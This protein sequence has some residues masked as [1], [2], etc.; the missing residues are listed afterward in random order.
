M[1]N[2]LEAEIEARARGRH[3]VHSAPV[4][5]G[6][7]DAA[8]A[9]QRLNAL[10]HE[11]AAS[12]MRMPLADL[13]PAENLANYGIDSI[14]ITE[15][16]VQISRRLG[17]AVAPTTFF[18]ARNLI[19]L[20]GLLEQR[21]GG[22]V[23]AALAAEAPGAP[24][25][26]A[27]A[28]AAPDVDSW[29]RRHGAVRRKA[30]AKHAPATVTPE[31]GR[32]AMPIAII[33][34]QGTFPK[35]PDIE[36]LRQHLLK[37]E[38]CIEVV[39]EERW[40]WRDVHG[41]PRKGPFTDVKYGGF[42]PDAD[43]FDA[44]FFGI[45][46]REAELIDPQHRLFME[47]VWGLLETAGHAPSRLAGRKIGLFL[48]INL[49]DY[50]EMANRAGLREAQQLT[51]L[52]HA[53]CPNRLSFLLDIH[54]PSEVID[55]ACSSSLVAIHRAV[56]SIRHEGCEMAIAGGSNLMLSPMQHIMFSR[57]GMICADGRCKTFSAAA[58]GYARADGVG[59]VLLKPLADA[60]RDNDR[61]LGVILAS[62][63]H[64][65]GGA[66]SLTAPNPQAQ[67][68]L[69]AEAHREARV[70]PRSIG[71]IECHGTG[72][73]L[74]DPIEIEGL[75][76]AFDLL[77]R[78][79]GLAPPAVPHIGLGSIK[80][81]IGH[82]ET[83]AGVAG[84][85][86]TLLA[87]EEGTR[88]R[89]LHCEE[90]NPLID[91]GGSPFMLLDR[92]AAWPR[93][94]IDGREEPRRAG[95]SSFG[96]GGTNVHIVVEEYRG[97][98]SLPAPSAALHVVP[99]SAR[100]AEALDGLLR[101]MLPHVPRHAVRDLAGTLQFGRDAFAHR[102]AFVAEDSRDLATQIERFLSGERSGTAHGV[103][104]RGAA[105]RRIEEPGALTPRALADLWA[106]GADV[107][108][109]ALAGA[110][111]FQR[112]PL[113]SY[114]FE[115]RRYWLPLPA[116]KAPASAQ[117]L[118]QAGEGLFHATL[119]ATDSF[120]RDHMVN[121]VP[122][123]PGVMYLE[124]ARDAATRAGL[125]PVALRNVTWLQ[126]LQVREE[127]EVSIRL[128]PTA[129]Q[130]FRI[131]ITSGGGVLHAQMTASR[132]DGG[133]ASH[134][135]K[136]LEA[137]HRE[138]LD[139]E[140]IYR[141]HAERGIAFG[142]AHRSLSSLSRAREG[143]ATV[144][145]LARISLPPSVAGTLTG[146][147]LHPSI[148]DGALQAA[149]GM[150]PDGETGT[151][152][153]FGLTGLAG[154]G[155]LGESMHVFIRPSAESGK[156]DLDLIDDEGNVVY[157]LTGFATRALQAP[158]DG[159]ALLAFTPAWKQLGPA[160]AQVSSEARM[161][162]A[163]RRI[164]VT[165]PAREADCTV[166]HVP[167]TGL[168]ARAAAL[169]KILGQ[170]PAGRP[171]LVQLLLPDDGAGPALHATLQT[172]ALEIPGLRTQTIILE[173]GA[174]AGTAAA[175]LAEQPAGLYRR[176]HGRFERLGHE[177]AALPPGDFP[178]RNTGVYLVTGGGGALGQAV[179]RWVK[180]K[181]P[182]AI[183][184]RM[185]R[186]RPADADETFIAADAA[187]RDEVTGM[188]AMIRAR[189]GA[190][191]GVFHCAGLLRDAPL[192]EKTTEDFAAVLAPKLTAARILDE[193]IGAE[194][195]DA[196]VLF[197]S[198]SGVFGNPGQADYA[199]ANAA[200]DLFAEDRAR[201]VAAGTR[202]GATISIAWPLWQ[203]G[204][205]RMSPETIRLM[206]QTTGLAPLPLAHG[207]DALQRAMAARFPRLAIGFGEG[208]K[209][210][211]RFTMD[212]PP[213]PAVSPSR[214]PSAGLRNRLAEEL[215]ACAAGQLKVSVEDLATN[216]ELT[217]YGFD[218]I[219]F[220]QFANAL[221]DRFGLEIGPTLFFECQTI[222]LLAEK[223]A[224]THG[225]M[226]GER[227]GLV[228][229]APASPPAAPV[230]PPQPAVTREAVEARPAD[231]PVAIISM[232]GIFPGAPDI[233]TFWRNLSE[234][235]DSIS[236]IPPERW[237]WRAIWGNPQKED[238][239]TNVKWGGF[240]DG[241][242]EFDAAFFGLSAPEARGTDPQQRLLLTESWKLFERAGIAPQS[243]SGRRIGVFIGI[244][245]TGYGRLLAGGEA[246]QAYMM[247]G[248]APS[249]G[250]NRI[251]HFYNL[252]GPSVAVETACSSAL[253][254]VH[255]AAESIRAGECE[256]A[257]AGGVNTLLLPD[258]YI[259]FSR[260]GMLSA[261]G[262]SKPFS[263]D[264]NGYARGE[265]IGLFL[266]KPLSA[267][268]RDGDEI[269][270]VIR[271][272]AENHGGRASSLTAPNPRAQAD[273]LRGVYRKANIDPRSVS[274]I[275]AHGTGT[276]LGDPI[277][278][279]A[280]SAAFTTLVGEAEARHGAGPALRCA[281][282]SVKSNIGHLEIAAGAA[283]L[284]KVLLQIRHRTI[285]GT[286]HAARIN[287]LL[288]LEGSG[289][290]VATATQ[291]WTP[292]RGAGG[293]PLPLRA[294]VSSFGFGGANAHLVV[295]AYDG[296]PRA[297]P[298]A[299][300]N[301]PRMIVVSARNEDQL[302][303]T[304]RNLAGA[305]AAGACSLGDAAFTLATGRDAMEHRLAF[306]ATSTA[307]AASHLA[308]FAR[309]ETFPGLHRGETR[310]SRALVGALESDEAITAAIEGLA[311]RGGQD[312]LLRLWVMGV[313]VDWARVMPGGRRAAL[314]TY[315]FRREHFWPRK[316]ASPAAIPPAPASSPPPAAE[317]ADQLPPPPREDREA[318]LRGRLTELAAA[319]LEVQPSMIDAEAELGDYGFDSVSMT[320]FAARV[321]ADLDL[322]LTPPDFFTFPTIAKLAGH[323]L[324]LKPGVSAARPQPVAGT[325]A[326]ALPAAMDHDGDPIVI[327]GMSCEF[328]GARG[329]EE[330]WTAL[331]EG[332]D[333]ITRIPAGRWDWRALDGDPRKDPGKTD[334]H[335]GGFIEGL[336]E[337]D[338]L[339]FNIAPR[340]ARY[341]DPQHRLMMLH[342]WKAIE[343][344]GESPRALAG[345]RGGVFVGTAASGYRDI[346]GADTGTE[347][348]V[349]TGSVA[350]IG[351]NRISYFLDW[352]G[353]SEP[354]ETACSSS[355]VA[356]HRACQAIENG[357]CDFALAGGV[358]SIVTPEAHINF[359]KA[360]MLAPDGRC[361][362]FSADA[363]GYVRGEGVGMI[364][365]KRLSAALRD[366]NPVLAI[367]KGTAVN[368]GGKAN[369]L[370]AP[371]GAAQAELLTAAWRKAGIDP[372]TI[373]YI[374][375]HGTGTALGDPV[376]I[377]AIKSAWASSADQEAD[378]APRCAIGA[379]KTNIGHLELAAGIAGVIKTVLQMQAGTLAP[380]L[381]AGAIN[382]YIS[383]AGT[384][385]RLLSRAE[386][387]ERLVTRQGH[388]VPRRAG[389]S[390]FGYGG[391]NS[392]VVLEE[393]IP[394]QRPGALPGGPLPIVLSAHDGE[395][396]RELA[397][398]L[399]TW[400][401]DHPLSDEGLADFAYTLQAGRTAMRHRLAFAARSASE[402]REHLS[403]Y[404]RGQSGDIATGIAPPDRDH[405]PPLRLAAE[406]AARGWVKGAAI[407]WSAFYHGTP[408]R[409]RLPSY[410]F[411][412]EI[413]RFDAAP[414][415]KPEITPRAITLRLTPDTDGLSDHRFQGACVVP[416]AYT[417][418]LA[419]SH[420]NLALPL[421][422]QGTLWSRPLAVPESGLELTLE[423]T[424]V[425]GSAGIRIIA[426]G[427]EAMR[428]SA[429][430]AGQPPRDVDPGQLRQDCADAVSPQ[431][432]YGAFERLGLS[433]GP[434]YRA[435][436]GLWRGPGQ[437]LAELGLP[438]AARREMP[439][440]PELLDAAFQSALALFLSNSGE[441]AL[442]FALTSFA[443][444]Q[445]MPDRL[446]AH[447]RLR[448]ASPTQVEID[449]TLFDGQGRVIA[450]AEGFTARRTPAPSGAGPSG[451]GGARQRITRML[452]EMVARETGV[453]AGNIE[454]ALPL[455]HYGIDSLLIT[456]LTEALERHTGP[457]PATLFFEHRSIDE[458][459]AWLT[460]RHASSLQ[461]TAQNPPAQQ[462]P[463][464]AA[465]AAHVTAQEAIAIVG[466]AGRYPGA[467]NIEQFWNALAAGRD[468]VTTIPPGRWDHD[469]FYDPQPGT[470]GRTNSRWGGFIDGHDRF[471]PLFF[472]IAPGEAEY[473]D[474][475]ERLFL[476]CAWE[477]LEDS[478]HTRANLAPL[479][480]ALK[481]GNVGVFV[482]VMYE[483]YQLYGAERSM[484]GQPVA[485]GGSAA[486]IANR[487]S[488]FCDFHGPSMTV[489]T[490]CSS[491]LTAIHLAC[492]SIRSGSCAAA[493]AG[494]VN[495]TL[496]PNKYIALS[497][498]RFL[499]S[500][501]RCAAFGQ[502]G[503]GY[504][505]GE[506]VGAVVLKPLSLAL[507]DGN[508]IHAVIRGSAL[509]HGGKTNGYTVP[510]PAAQSA[511][512]SNAFR[513]AGVNPADVS[514]VEAHG[515]GTSL[516][517]PIEI[518][519]LARAFGEGAQRAA[520][521]AIGSVKSNI[522][523]CESAAGIAGLT[524]IL[525]QMRH[526]ALAPSLHA[527]S[528]NPALRLAETPFVVQTQL[529]PWEPAGG[530]RLASLSSFGA[531]GSN[532]HVL[533][534]DVNNE[535]PALPSARMAFPLSARTQ[536]RLDALLRNMAGKLAAL[537]EALIPHAA[538][539]LQ[540]GRESFE[541]RVVLLARSKEDLLAALDIAIKGGSGANVMRGHVRAP[542]ARAVQSF[543]G[544]DTAARAWCAG[545][546]VD[547]SA[548]RTGTGYRR[549]SL[550]TYAF[551]QDRFWIPGTGTPAPAA[552]EA[553]V[554]M[555][556]LF[557]PEWREA[558]LVKASAPARCLT[559]LCDWPG[560]PGEIMAALGGTAQCL[561]HAGPVAGRYAS[562]AKRLV[563]IIQQ[564]VRTGAEKTCLQLVLPLDGEGDLM[565]GLSGL[566]RTAR[567]EHPTLQAQTIGI[568]P[569]TPG[570]PA[571]ILEERES[572]EPDIRYTGGKRL[573]RAWREIAAPDRPASPWREGGAY[574][575]TG[576]AGA[577][578]L[579]LCEDIAANAPGATI[580]LAH[581]SPL[582]AG[583]SERFSRLRATVHA[584]QT[585][586]TDAR[587]VRALADEITAAHGR[588]D[589]LIHAAGTT[590]DRMLVQKPAQEVDDVLRPKV[591]GWES[592][593]DA[594]AGREPALVLLFAS[595]AGALGN[596]GQADYAAANAWLDAVAA[597]HTAAR[598]I[599]IDWPYWRDG[600]MRMPQAAVE[601]M[602]RVTG[603][604]PLETPAALKALHAIIQSSETQ[605]LVLDGDHQRLRNMMRPA[606][607]TPGAGSKSPAPAPDLAWLTGQ[608]AD[609][610]KIPADQIDPEAPLDRYGVDSIQ[611]L[612]IVE[613]LQQRLGPLPPTLLLENPSIA[614]LARALNAEK[615]PEVTPAPAVRPEAV[616][617]GAA[618]EDGAIAIIGVA[619]RYPG[620]ETLDAFW[621]ALRDGADCITEI[622]AGRWPADSLGFG[623]R[624]EAGKS[625]C[626]LGGFISRVDGFD[627]P[628]FGYTPRQAE[629]ADPQE[630]LFLETA[631]HALENASHTRRMLRDRYESSVGVFVGAM[632][633]QYRA[634]EADGEARPQLTLAS[635]A[636]IANRLSFF[637][638]AQG[639]SVAVDSM[640]SAG[641]QAVHQACQ[642][643]R[644]G[645]CRLA[646]AGGVNLTI[647]PDKYI[648]LSRA[649]L[650][651]SHRGSRS[652][653]DGDGYLP[654]EGVGAVVLKPL[655]AAR[656][657]G[658]R[659]LGIIRASAAN[660]AGHSA[661]YASPSA[662][663]QARLVSGNFAASGI[664]PRTI[665]Y[666]EA[667]ANGS[668]LGDAIEMRALARAFAALP[669]G[670]CAIGS[671]KANIGHAE[672]ASGLAQLTK[673]LLQFEHRMLAPMPRIETG[674]PHIDFDALPFHLPAR[675]GPWERPLVDG[676]LQ[677]RRASISAFGAGG[678]N[679]HLI[680]EEPPATEA[681]RL[682]RSGGQS[683]HLFV[684]SAPTRERLHAVLR[685]M[686]DWLEGHHDVSLAALASAL[687]HRRERWR[688]QMSISAATRAELL[689][690]LTQALA[691]ASFA[692]T[693]EDPPGL[694][695]DALPTLPAYPFAAERHWLQPLRQP[696][697][698]AG[699]HPVLRHIAAET[700][701]DPAQIDINT[702]LTGLGLD[703]MAQL[704]LLT[705]LQR[706][707]GLTLSTRDLARLPT[708]ADIIGATAAESRPLEQPVT[709]QARDDAP[710]S[711]PLT[712]NQLGLYAQQALDPR[713]FAYNVPIAFRCKSLDPRLAA[714]AWRA[715]LARHPILS[716]RVTEKD[717]VLHLAAGTPV[718]DLALRTAAHAV[719]DEAQARA[720][721]PFDL[722]REGVCR[723][724]LIDGPGEDA[725]LLITAHHIAV[726]GLSAVLIAK[727]F[728]SCYARLL[729]G[730]ALPPSAGK[731]FRSHA[732][733][734]ARYLASPEARQD[735]EWWRETLAGARRITPV[736][737]DGD[738]RHRP[739]FVLRRVTHGER[740]RWQHAAGAH[741][742]TLAAFCAAAMVATLHRQ[743]GET[744]I[745]MAMPTLGRDDADSLAMVG[746]C[747]NM[748]FLRTII[749]PAMSG[750]D[751]LR[752]V[753]EQMTAAASH[754]R[755]PFAKLAEQ[756][757]ALH[758]V[759]FA[760]QNFA[761][762]RPRAPLPEGVRPV[763]ELRQ[764]SDTLLAF[765]IHDTGEQLEFM[766]A[767]DAGRVS[768]ATAGL[769]LDRL[770]AS[771]GRI[772]GSPDQ[773]A[774]SIIEGEAEEAR[775]VRQ[776]S[777][778]EAL[779]G[780]TG[781]I[782]D[783][784]RERLR[785][786]PDAIAIVSDTMTLTC[787]QLQSR[788]NGMARALQDRG[789]AAGDRV[790]VLSG[791]EAQSVI[792]LLACLAL[793]SVWI[794]LSPDEPD[795]RLRRI[796]ADARPKLLV[797]LPRHVERA[798]RLH[799][800]GAILQLDHA[801]PT[802]GTTAPRSRR[803]E[804]SEPA[805]VIYT[806][807]T[808]GSPKG[809]VV[810]RG[811]LN[812]HCAAATVFYGIGPDDRVLQ[813]AAP[814]VDPFLEQTLPALACGARIVM[815][816][817]AM[818]SAAALK[819]MVDRNAITIADLPPAYLREVLL[820]LRDQGIMPPSPS[821]R[822]L[823]I[824]GE[825]P[826]ADLS[827]LWQAGPF[828]AAQLVNAYGPTEAAITCLAHRV[829][830]DERVPPIG[831]P[832]PGG[833]IRIVGRN[834][835]RL[836]S[837]ACGELLIG[838]ARLADGYLGSP[839]LTEERF[840]LLADDDGGEPRRFYRTGDLA[841]FAADGSGTILFHGRADTLVKIR[842]HR[843]DLG[844]IRA[845][846]LA[847]GLRDAAVRHRNGDLAAPLV[848]YCVPE[849]SGFD[850]D[851]LRGH[852]VR[853]LPVHM[854][855]THVVRVDR[856]P[857]NAAGKVDWQALPPPISGQAQKDD[858][859]L[860][861]EEESLR[862]IWSELLGISPGDIGRNDD[863]FA[864]GGH[865]LLIL[866]LQA[867]IA[868][869][870]GLNLP[871]TAFLSAS[872]LA[873]Q[874]ALIHRPS[875]AGDAESPLVSMRTGSGAPLLLV[876]PVGGGL[877]CYAPL[878]E[879]VLP[880]RPVYGF[881]APGVD[882]G[883]PW[884]GDLPGLAAS[885][886]KAASAVV[887][888][889]DWLLA[890]W[891]M[892]GVI[893]Q[894]MA[895]QLEDQGRRIGLL[896]LIDAYPAQALDQPDP[897]GGELRDFMVDLMGHEA[898]RLPP[899]EALQDMLEAGHLHGLVPDLPAAQLE[900][901]LRAYRNH[902][903][904]L[905]QHR[906][907]AVRTPVILV[908]TRAGAGLCM[909]AWS[910]LVSFAPAP[911]ILPA[912]HFTLLRPPV[913]RDVGA[914]LTAAVRT[915]EP[916]VP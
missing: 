75:K 454:T 23:A 612:R 288:K 816:G 760:Y 270:G 166:H 828:S 715:M 434:R 858:G 403:D 375:A 87:F 526:R 841:S 231:D 369:S 337:F 492:E 425:D 419:A 477:A 150:A 551:A 439:L 128:T 382:P 31:A 407:D 750:S 125:A 338:P 726:D 558:P 313:S 223:L 599:A 260:A 436:S 20:A 842:G 462:E 209:I 22:A 323:I 244:A 508:T 155:P 243:L 737:P 367:I 914:A 111:Q 170:H 602:R 844:E 392:H 584:R 330:F 277:E 447:L 529:A 432:V 308:A 694:T 13:D 702:P 609:A 200:L 442:P 79:R 180:E 414:P 10:V 865:S 147:V 363:N 507:R 242:D 486:T 869:Q 232:T 19:G 380:S 220:T 747:V 312:A 767:H 215:L 548:L 236:E 340:E 830:H 168:A 739:S 880:G 660:H 572:A 882:T 347:G 734:E 468:A 413:Y 620:G 427:Q 910:S 562:H 374:E 506:G 704:R 825:A 254:A 126:P 843:V 284:M 459:A 391:V 590:R 821:L 542:V 580:W 76:M 585:D 656:A 46:P 230:R 302:R 9:R 709:G 149:I 112:V 710:W 446:L 755:L 663:A 473:M 55:T 334:I 224:D 700:G 719:I 589:A 688:E 42:V 11:I 695:G 571:L 417:L 297:A 398:S 51:G 373:T 40:N 509:N 64:H 37:G 870:W 457:L 217:E 566:L 248:L 822:L 595:A 317:P 855:P 573:V 597:T 305:L 808:S 546:S 139:V 32:A 48:G 864:C 259:G 240:I 504:V 905:A 208:V 191:H 634:L 33:G 34:M 586:L 203:D 871:S 428:T 124:L 450:I 712:A 778:G 300:G 771:A 362:T 361:K 647:H 785:R 7:G 328:P 826:A 511:V 475:Q 219:G 307:Q 1:R 576:G 21:Y 410:P 177:E 804:G 409:M 850:A 838:G 636:S 540:E 370:T 701:A 350:S 775:L 167:E 648:A 207:L 88:F 774:A 30:P 894:E 819:E 58:N 735:Q 810:G 247:T 672:A 596:P 320:S 82:A 727:D 12:A 135:L 522:G 751:L 289:F 275:E 799:P 181:A 626:R 301:A 339:F 496:H 123:L 553:G 683:R 418:A 371:N 355:L 889:E 513:R 345:A 306:L 388:A 16:M 296:T 708:P 390:S 570:I 711:V 127:A 796:I 678:A 593:R 26:A 77:Y 803:T 246:T 342:A 206:G 404:L 667:A 411:A 257:I 113:P 517:D 791:Q 122:V 165:A 94:V 453:P 786:E 102:V 543:P 161:L 670:N 253:V 534:E 73:K 467:D 144:S 763:A 383:L 430:P 153:P 792:A 535:A 54:G 503:D 44:A 133:T 872:T 904:L 731:D 896:G 469:R 271:A 464:P 285:A 25:A 282:G 776:W 906:P 438:T 812:H 134:D 762:L 389:I 119:R 15:V 476:Q 225:G 186:T 714:A 723:A 848:A 331:R 202:H 234:G 901:L 658:D 263:A 643:L 346:I 622:P 780:D 666:V 769:L 681:P 873:S 65:G 185:G 498:S 613:G 182:G 62:A 847:S 908:A 875:S 105:A 194:P 598:T 61:I 172:A 527:E 385:F 57:V 514:Y 303:E 902:R 311:S 662:E 815:R 357:E 770:I 640:C 544:W 18:E 521:C 304:A 909:S 441:S 66:S 239:R 104:P 356:L 913:C 276:P 377:N 718:P 295:E 722:S 197:S 272:S 116:P 781:D 431:E 484:A 229:E 633:Q 420:S 159:H 286:L 109:E 2:A 101:S 854:V 499:S 721:E 97:G 552:P 592:L 502:G 233:E 859:A 840:I 103:A 591:H 360:G 6:T 287:P 426:G 749:E 497:Q 38:D 624:G 39:P 692:E 189:H 141:R 108:W 437:V 852:M 673:V 69:I 619:G 372:R 386:P 616:T 879:E 657:A 772:A 351:P 298:R 463:R 470:P 777:R 314:P 783:R 679:V 84:L 291:A 117:R 433:Y 645:E 250:P 83:A 268:L 738:G 789:I 784:I 579:T 71:M 565:E 322:E 480:G 898:H 545:E 757:E 861:A 52:G 319:T 376:E 336:Y 900:R 440:V 550:P 891:S 832:L 70:D 341:M 834:M 687:F 378:A 146:T 460:D 538:F 56:M 758:D 886:I 47:C 293:E 412:R 849:D 267:A 629:L 458:L 204:G 292:P 684:F 897:D 129:A 490:M 8:S 563:E 638:D 157:A 188:I 537:P 261:D 724:D 561:S 888:G 326:H 837:A 162:I 833:E 265:G 169:A 364:F 214:R 173:E 227:L 884:A 549:I 255:R 228:T 487:V 649:G 654:A 483:E 299:D 445:P 615:P 63:E 764:P 621:A 582:G 740:V 623:A 154:T 805:Y 807:G 632:Y 115:R 531:G 716:A 753:Q 520:P 665:S 278:F 752:K 646:I 912:D 650:I 754:G 49:L 877:A 557:A 318:W 744:D 862:R 533:L 685:A 698:D 488:Y 728:W 72:T 759:T 536:Q 183:V 846:L 96:A 868:G 50:V 569:D 193:A 266:L 89:T 516:G 618:D 806:S 890:G 881:R 274:Y 887:G 671:V 164:D 387:W 402:V 290:H 273:L 564:L 237:D 36:A 14:A 241:I 813:F 59:A 400:I 768:A 190:L 192:R 321:N 501:G 408:R 86:K 252:H 156:L 691:G 823:I 174:P 800:D 148:L 827:A 187:N 482:G 130:A 493:I 424:T 575:I 143:N 368:H 17:I 107:A 366:G 118:R 316:A 732:A 528:P 310:A 674:N 797:A 895:R 539:T 567:H 559:L 885:Y 238:G 327:V 494:G 448:T 35:S 798:S 178:W 637:L 697:R 651:G 281:I 280:L 831:R 706:D 720:W 395:R 746:F 911:L 603:A 381:H 179:A 137:Q 653:A 892:G 405:S 761:S 466:V 690:K 222:D 705:T 435:L 717:G 851:A 766:L 452:V 686:A 703:S 661:G 489:D 41:D 397:L 605:V 788:V 581:R 578:G 211:A 352:H 793:G 817:E 713:L 568:Q 628:F 478:G 24:A 532:A 652:F 332:R 344:A 68:R 335:W 676:K 279:E 415:V 365:V 53:F 639:P 394:R 324:S 631:W 110:R 132:A 756:Y 512:I 60:E 857:L 659:I 824:G 818:P 199:L 725:I 795:A 510:N 515:T 325:P 78:E 802:R 196:F 136:A 856:I 406:D 556:L 91:L 853:A 145:V 74:G 131:E 680:V 699:F 588:L 519:A 611:S 655:A 635:Y 353:P 98:P 814:H 617:T 294:G 669:R 664:D 249:L 608:I 916:A 163:D 742:I 175:V 523:H 630:R 867:R 3:G 541:E 456:R 90:P 809:V 176:A 4:P 138:A 195:L 120:L 401:E 80:S 743:T 505:P 524:K 730:E 283:G 574:L 530:R 226:L 481:G 140:A 393:F 878:L 258:S 641:L 863:F 866:R 451:G 860:T 212:P 171:T 600:G 736:P 399:R 627:A 384:P 264:A 474:P 100:S 201:R 625:H 696:D 216:V 269:H 421:R 689:E 790:A 642:S 915:A 693:G 794:P 106:S 835:R 43:K 560:E 221:N 67:S 471:D 606:L 27:E 845:A 745:A 315:P 594:F 682:A 839:D 707:C 235:V 907:R 429:R 607:P 836:P 396:L 379:V 899:P 610:L 423:R 92:G 729:R 359:A 29:L 677:P 85:I 525:L 577:I 449:I 5:A 329:P 114:P 587:S 99:F 465:A 485:L 262:R 903:R 583:M 198:L 184:I 309:G 142:P 554:R 348:F 472:N 479:D 121:G 883:E 256:C 733:A 245:D 495:L 518:A 349:A 500:N 675:L 491:S 829:T 152:L 461:Q 416:G 205:M 820:S 779:P 614:L 251:S 601:T 455:E 741:G 28:P 874:A 343:D 81:N 443:L 801:V 748:V 765:E 444:F 876:H 893:A 604:E 213:P 95:I 668:P 644:L 773:P 811:A 151:A 158:G 210:R 354:V 333:C 547:W 555:P 160:P 787:R 45:S 782:F 93:P 218:S 358:N 422:L